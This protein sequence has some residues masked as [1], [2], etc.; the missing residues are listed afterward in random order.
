M[1][2]SHKNEEVLRLVEEELNMIN[3]VLKKQRQLV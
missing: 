2:R 1:A 3:T